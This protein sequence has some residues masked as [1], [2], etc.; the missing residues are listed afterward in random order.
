MDLLS[1]D[2]MTQED[3]R[4][5]QIKEDFYLKLKTQQRADPLRGINLPPVKKEEDIDAEI[6]AF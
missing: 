4:Q 3:R 5:S 6:K 1:T 2:F